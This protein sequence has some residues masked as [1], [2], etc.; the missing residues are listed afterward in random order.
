MQDPTQPPQVNL[1]PESLNAMSRSFWNSA[2]LR[3][4]IKLGVFELIEQGPMNSVDLARRLG[5]SARFLEAL[6]NACVALG[7]LEQ[8]TGQGYHLVQ[9]VDLA[10]RRTLLDMG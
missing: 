2:I 10:G 8:E 1:D 5:A 3:A 6:L 4:G 7:P 9:N